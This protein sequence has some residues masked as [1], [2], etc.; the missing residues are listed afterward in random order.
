M[1]KHINKAKKPI[2]ISAVLYHIYTQ[3]VTKK[4][5]DLKVD[6]PTGG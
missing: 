6:H 2:S 1:Y 4:Y 3:I 5:V